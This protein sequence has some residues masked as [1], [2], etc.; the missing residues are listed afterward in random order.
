MD[1]VGAAIP[2]S[3]DS[4]VSRERLLAILGSRIL[5]LLFLT[6]RLDLK[7]RAGLSR[8]LDEFVADKVEGGLTKRPTAGWSE[9]SPI[10]SN[11]TPQSPPRDRPPGRSRCP[12]P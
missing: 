2:L 6:L 5:R 9:G 10:K 11:V 12:P 8:K 7:D 3:K 1:R 4:R